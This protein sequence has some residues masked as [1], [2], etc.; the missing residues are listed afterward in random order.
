MTPAENRPEAIALL[1]AAVE[2]IE[3]DPR[4]FTASFFVAYPWADLSIVGA[5]TL[6]ITVD[7][8]G[9]AQRYARQ[10]ADDHVG[11]PR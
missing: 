10:L 6:C 9:A 3:S 7:D 11:H 1:A 2:R 8:A 4:V 5:S